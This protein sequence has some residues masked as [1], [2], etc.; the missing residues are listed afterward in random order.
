MGRCNRKE[1]HSILTDDIVTDLAIDP[2]QKFFVVAGYGNSGYGDSLTIY[3]L[4]SK[5][6]IRKLPVV[7]DKG[8][9]SGVDVSI[10]P[11]GKL[12]AVGEDNR[13]VNLYRT[14]D[15]SLVKTLRPEDGSCGGCG[16][17]A[18]FSPDNR[19]LYSASNHGA[20]T[21]YEI[22]SFNVVKTYHDKTEDLVGF[23]LSPDGKTIARASEKEIVVWDEA[24]GDSIAAIKANEQGEF[25]EIEFARNSRNLLVTSDD[26][27]VF[28]WNYKAGKSN[29]T[30]R[31]FES[32]RSRWTGL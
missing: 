4:A 23:A 11:D 29:R 15:W 32:A 27:T 2:Q 19:F 16:T 31:L 10:S 30:H 18:I 22:P 3:D 25:H 13:T 28:S 12:L 8:L 17:R 7:A 24:S 20:I 5:S 21:K 6:K 14:S 9:G 26:N 1:I